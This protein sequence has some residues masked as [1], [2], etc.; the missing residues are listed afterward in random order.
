MDRSA[1]LSKKKI[2]AH[3]KWP[4]L[5]MKL[6]SRSVRQMELVGKIKFCRSFYLFFP[7]C[8]QWK[9]SIAEKKGK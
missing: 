7:W 2:V 9:S 4:T 3:S 5:K 8:S 6:S 1:F